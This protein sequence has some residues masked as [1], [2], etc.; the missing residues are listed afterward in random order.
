MT[1]F[2]DESDSI[3]RIM[4]D[5]FKKNVIRICSKLFRHWK[6]DKLLILLE[7]S[8]KIFLRM[9]RGKSRKNCI[10]ESFLGGK[11]K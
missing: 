6:V 11:E 3:L 7:Q 4:I 9:V 5:N 8:R 1:C 10:A 2:E